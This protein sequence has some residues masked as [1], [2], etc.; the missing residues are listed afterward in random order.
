[1]EDGML[2]EGMGEGEPVGVEIEEETNSYN[3][4]ELATIIVSSSLIAL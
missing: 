3:A 4:K 2:E 1:M